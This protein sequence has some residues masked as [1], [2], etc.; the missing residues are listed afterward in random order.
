VACSGQWGVQLGVVFKVEAVVIGAGVIGLAIARALASRGIQVVVLENESLVGSGT[1]SRNS[2][3]IHAGLYYE[4]GSLKARL[5][6]DGRHMLYRYCDERHL[7]CRQCGK[8]VI[9][10]DEGEESYLAKLLQRARSN[11]VE[12]IELIGRKGLRDLEPHVRGTSALLSPA[13]GIVDSHAL[14]LSYQADAEAAGAVI[15]LR[16]PVV[17]GAVAGGTIQL[18]TGA[19]EAAELDAELV[20]NAAGLHAWDLSASITGLNHGTIPPRVFAKGNYFTLSG[21]KAPFRHL[22]YPVPEPGGLGIHLTLDLAGNAR[23]GP[24]VEWVDNIDYA[25][26]PN[27]GQRFYTSIRRYWP[28]LPDGALVPAYSGIRPKTARTDPC[29]FIIQGPKTSGHDGYI[30][31]YG[32]ESPGL[33]AALA[34]G[35]HVAQLA[36]VT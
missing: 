12:D 10:T 20:V 24:D 13:S 16:T 17:A 18:T 36:G 25:V 33:T 9:A 15:A 3:V 23:F 19:S 8:L 26:D 7:P 35:D 5:C 22:I 6:V 27:R 34:I 2:E 29:D 1:S 30:A 32:M 14:M 4:P 31:L 21:A 28:D 11:G